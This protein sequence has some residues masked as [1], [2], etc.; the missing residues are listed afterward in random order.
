[1]THEA[2]TYRLLQGRG[3]M[4]QHFGEPLRLDPAAPLRRPAPARATRPDD[5]DLPRAA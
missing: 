2:T 1:M 3:I 4:I 5:Y